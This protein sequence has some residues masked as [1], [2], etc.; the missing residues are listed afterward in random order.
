MS[1]SALAQRFIRPII[2]GSIIAI[3]WM[4]WLTGNELN[5]YVFYFLPAGLAGWYL[6]LG[7]SVS[8]A[9][10]CALVWYGADYLAGHSHS[11][12]SFAAWN[13]LMR[14]CSFL[15]IGYSAYKIHALLIVERTATEALRQSLAEIKI[16][17]GLLRICAECKRIMNAQGDWQKLES[18]VSQHSQATFTH[19]Y[20]PECARRF[21]ERA[22]LATQKPNVPPEG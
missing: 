14:L 5:F 8:V 1:D 7:G 9:V 18:Y 15:A 2:L 21:L 12:V 6:G 19:G 22:G 3:G 11:S 13:T 16:L 10:G 17:E 4:D 20:C